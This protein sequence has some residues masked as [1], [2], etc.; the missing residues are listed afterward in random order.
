MRPGSRVAILVA[1]IVPALALPA[2]LGAQI[3]RG[4]VLA[5]SAGVI[6]AEVEA[7]D[8][9]G[10]AVTTMTDSLGLFLLE[11]PVAGRYTV[12]ARHPGHTPAGPAPVDVASD[13]EVMLLIRMEAVIPLAPIEVTAR[14]RYGQNALRQDVEAR[15]AWSERLGFG[16]IMRREEIDRIP[17]ADVRDLLMGTPSVRVIQ[18]GAVRRVYFAGAGGD[19]M[20]QVYVDGV[21]DV[22][23]Q[24]ML[25]LLSPG[26]LEVVE[27]YRSSLEAPPEYFDPGNCGVLLFWTRRD[28]A[29]GKAWNWKRLLALGTVVGI[30]ILL[31]R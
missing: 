30:M 22:T 10:A 25:D 28:A 4:R 3:L 9:A 27:I 19:C 5:D 24:G 17:V 15:L 7:V 31:V 2:T 18:A 6:G 29:G 26:D 14:R 21:R 23:R 13:E 8:T 1:G 16:R 20:P 12:S 11:L